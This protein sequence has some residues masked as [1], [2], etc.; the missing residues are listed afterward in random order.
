MRFMYDSVTASDIPASAQMV[1]GYVSGPY[2]WSAA[3]WARFPDAVHVPIA[4][5]AD[6][7][8]GI[9]LDVEQGDATPDQAPGWVTMRRKAGI[10]PTVYCGQFSW[11]AVQAAF[12]TAGVD[13]PHY[14][15]AHYDNAAVLPDGAV[16]KQY[17]NPGLSGGHYDLSIV[18]DDWPGIDKPVAAQEEEDDMDPINLPPAPSGGARTIPWTG[19]AAVLNVVGVSADVEVL[20]IYCWGPNGGTGGG[21]PLNVPQLPAVST[22]HIVGVNQPGAF[23]IPAGTTRVFYEWISTDQHFVQIVAV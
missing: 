9:V 18:A 14:W 8:D 10:D 19:K 6:V 23:A 3:D 4:T 12:R 2:Q 13:Q 22:G 17:A 11:L 15:I 20:P 7:D 1:A 5:H 21:N 16:A